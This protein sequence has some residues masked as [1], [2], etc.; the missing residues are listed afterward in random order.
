MRK[1]K[2]KA[3]KKKQMKNAKFIYLVARTT[4]M[5]VFAHKTCH[6]SIKGM[7]KCVLK[8]Y[9]FNITRI[10]VMILTMVCY[11]LECLISSGR[12]IVGMVFHRFIIQLERKG[13]ICLM[14]LA[15]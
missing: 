2:K 1:K 13:I 7:P 8:I 10:F 12:T 3:I 6:C 5:V 9:S 4:F 15:R 11:D 14:I